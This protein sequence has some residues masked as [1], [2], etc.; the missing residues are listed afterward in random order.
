MHF[1][2]SILLIDTNNNKTNNAVFLQLD[3]M[4][5]GNETIQ[6][7]K[8]EIQW[9]IITNNGKCPNVPHQQP[10]SNSHYIENDKITIANCHNSS[11]KYTQIDDM[12]KKKNRKPNES[13]KIK[14][15]PK[16][17]ETNHK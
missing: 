6:M 11:T 5:V 2:K 9:S 7:K 16:Q 1:C 15:K 10:P 13:K 12:Y 8:I 3:H 17:T 4:E 14:P